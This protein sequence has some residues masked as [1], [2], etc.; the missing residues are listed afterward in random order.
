[1]V[2][3]ERGSRG[4][5][6][7][8]RKLI[9]KWERKCAYCGAY[10]VSLQIEHIHPKAKGGTNRVSNLCLACGPCNLKKGTQDIEVF[11]FP[12]EEARCLEESVCTSQASIV[13]KSLQFYL[14]YLCD[15]SLMSIARKCQS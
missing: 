12:Q 8:A 15:L 5:G 2:T 4:E 1:M 7:L 14:R 13:I 11:G 6:E 3:T 9:L 10:N